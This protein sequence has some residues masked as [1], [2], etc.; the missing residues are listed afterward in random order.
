M[1]QILNAKAENPRAQLAFDLFVDRLRSYIASLLPTLGGLDALVFTAGIGEHAAMVRSA[2][3]NGFE[4]LGW[5]LDDGLNNN[6]PVDQDI[7]TAAS[8]V[9]ILVVHT[10]ED[11]AIAKDCWRLVKSMN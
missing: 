1:R 6:S 7:A 2:V 10:E 4:F 5:Q 3:C 9:R 11:W 8:A